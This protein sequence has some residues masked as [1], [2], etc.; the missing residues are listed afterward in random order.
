MSNCG[1]LGLSNHAELAP[2]PLLDGAIDVRIVL[3]KLLCVLAPLPQTFATISKPRA[4]F[5][6]DPPVDGEVDE[7]ARARDPFAIHDVELGLAERRRH[8]VLH[9]LHPRAATDD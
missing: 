1:D 6:D 7:I 9:D 8:L 3:E 2:D 5:F 4:R